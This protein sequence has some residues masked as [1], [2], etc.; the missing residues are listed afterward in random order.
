MKN[1]FLGLQRLS[2]RI[3][4]LLWFLNFILYWSS[5]EYSFDYPFP[6][7]LGQDPFLLS[8]LLIIISGIVFSYVLGSFVLTGIKEDVSPESNKIDEL[9]KKLTEMLVKL[10]VQDEKITQIQRDIHKDVQKG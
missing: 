8:S 2:F 1:F 10:E 4:V 6:E 5:L 3:H 9:D 7:I